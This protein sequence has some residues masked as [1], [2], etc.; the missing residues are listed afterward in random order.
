MKQL[1]N[2]NKLKIR[3]VILEKCSVPVGTVPIYQ[4]YPGRGIDFTLED[5]LKEIEKQAKDGVDF[6]TIHAGLT[7]EVLDDAR[8]R[9]IPITS[10]LPYSFRM[11]I[12][13]M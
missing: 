1:K 8:K 12:S 10:R 7:N 9:L 5:Y 2:T 13:R 6:M 4:V 11:E 3:K